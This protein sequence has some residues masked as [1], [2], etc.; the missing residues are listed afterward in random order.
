MDFLPDEHFASAREIAAAAAV[1]AE[2][3][4]AQL[5][6]D[7][8]GLVSKQALAETLADQLRLGDACHGGGLLDSGFEVFSQA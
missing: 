6:G 7:I 1:L 8:R 5:P 3:I 2:Q 4:L